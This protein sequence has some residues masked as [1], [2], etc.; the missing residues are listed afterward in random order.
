MLKCLQCN[1]RYPRVI[2]KCYRKWNEKRFTMGQNISKPMYT[3]YLQKSMKLWLAKIMGLYF[4][5]F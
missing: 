4:K 2:Q 5:Y 3:R 1:S